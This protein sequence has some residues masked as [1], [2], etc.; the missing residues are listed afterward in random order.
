MRDEVGSFAGAEARAIV[1]LAEPAPEF[2]NEFGRVAR[3]RANLGAGLSKTDLSGH[4]DG[5]SG[6]ASDMDRD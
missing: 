2:A 5:I 1:G 3:Q 6:R 4:A